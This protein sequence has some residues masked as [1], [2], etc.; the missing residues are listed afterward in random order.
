MNTVRFILISWL[1]LTACA[2]IAPSDRTTVQFE[3]TEVS[4][5][6]EERVAEISTILAK[7][8]ALPTPLSDAYFVEERI[9]DGVLGPS[10]YRSFARLDIAPQD[11]S[12]WQALLT[13]LSATPEFAAP[14]QAYEWWLA[15]EDFAS[16]RFYAPNTITSRANGWVAVDAQHGRI[17]IFTYTT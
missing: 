16:L 4:G 15:Q 5:T 1:L 8:Q 9:G 2:P 10:D 7:S 11:V 13:L 6:Q 3:V 12:K 14:R 17:Y